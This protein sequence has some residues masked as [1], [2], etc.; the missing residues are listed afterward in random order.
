MIRT[1]FVLYI[2]CIFFLLHQNQLLNVHPPWADNCVDANALC[3][4][5][6]LSGYSVRVLNI[7][8]QQV[9]VQ[10]VLKAEGHTI[11]LGGHLLVM[12]VK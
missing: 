8:I 1:L 12:V 7:V 4:L 6:E 10:Y 3:S 9:V 11:L 2:C 5:D